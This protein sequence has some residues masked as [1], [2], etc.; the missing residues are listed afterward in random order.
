MQCFRVVYRGIFYFHLYFHGLHT[1]LF[2][3][4]AAMPQK[5]QWLTQEAQFRMGKLGAIPASLKLSRGG[6]LPEKLG[7]GV[8]PASQNPYPIYD[9][10][11][12]NSIPCL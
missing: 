4:F 1:L 3:L 10:N 2:F 9:Q 11:Q 6:V 12:L 5:M 7:G 8:R